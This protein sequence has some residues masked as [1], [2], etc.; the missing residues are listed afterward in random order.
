MGTSNF[1]N[2]EN[3][4]YVMPE[5]TFEFALEFILE[6]RNDLL[7][8]DEPEVTKEDIDDGEVYQM[9]SQLD[10]DQADY[11]L[12]YILAELPSGMYAKEQSRYAY[13]V[14]NKQ[15]KIIAECS[16]QSGY[17][18]GYQVIVETDPV[19]IKSTRAYDG[20]PQS[21]LLEV[22]SP[23]HKRLLKHIAKYTTALTRVGGFSDGTSVYQRA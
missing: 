8:P 9:M 19:E 13:T 14:Y 7:E 20:Y 3:G 10:A 1:V 11:F 21:E 18:E 15:G 23:H 5:E 4:I 16:L 6:T 22:Y 17:Y 12:D 2:H